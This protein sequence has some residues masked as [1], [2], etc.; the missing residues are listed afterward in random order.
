[1]NLWQR[2]EQVGKAARQQ[3]HL[4]SIPNDVEVIEESGIPFVLRYA[5]ALIEKIRSY[6]APRRQ[7]PFLPP[8]PDLFVESVG[9]TH[10]LILNKYNVL[11]I[12]GL[13]TTKVFVEQTDLLSY[14]DFQAV[15]LV[16][17]E[18]DGLVFYNGGPT[19]GASQAHRH[20]QIVPKDLGNGVLPIDD[21]VT[22]WHQHQLSHIF[23][24]QHRLFWLP[25]LDA[26]SL[27]DAWKKME[28]SCQP[29]N[30]L[31]TRQWMM[32]IPRSQESAGQ[33]SMNSLAFAGA[34]L[35]KNELEID[36]IKR[37]GI[38]QMLKE[39]SLPL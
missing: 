17:S 33:I 1:M 12:H 16:L 4:V 29:Y 26:D 38:L 25:N 37:R 27:L 36:Y 30:L 14:D 7:N 28:Y 24:F 23:P 21:A 34:L 8:E 31:I 3:G 20:F 6:G 22:Q 35:A 9:E 11:P 19:A 13:I 32:V 2:M 10:N 39:V 18:V 15:A 5:P